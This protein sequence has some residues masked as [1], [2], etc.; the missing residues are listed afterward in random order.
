LVSPTLLFLVGLISF[1]VLYNVYLGFFRVNALQ[2]GQLSWRGPLNYEL[3][4]EDLEFWAS[5]QLTSRPARLFRLLS[6]S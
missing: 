4:F 2:P 5:F 6:R 3:I 1:P